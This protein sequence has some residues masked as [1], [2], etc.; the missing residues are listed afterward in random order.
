M[1]A[2]SF[3]SVFTQAQQ[4]PPNERAQLISALAEGLAQPAISQAAEISV[5]ERRARINAF[6]GKYRDSLSSVDE[7]LA[8]KRDEVELEESRYLAWHSEKAEG[9]QQ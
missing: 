3:E 2:I 4:L 7:F 6:R 1:S 8:A 5:E 9:A